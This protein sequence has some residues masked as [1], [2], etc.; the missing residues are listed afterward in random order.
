MTK[1][2]EENAEVKIIQLKEKNMYV[3]QCRSRVEE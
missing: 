2:K 3:L 1:K